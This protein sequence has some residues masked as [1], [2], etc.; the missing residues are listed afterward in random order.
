MA[1]F[2][3][4][5]L[6]GK[7]AKKGI[8]Y[9][10]VWKDFEDGSSAA[11]LSYVGDMF[12]CDRVLVLLRTPED[13]YRCTDEWCGE[14]VKSVRDQLQELTWLD[15]MPW[16]DVVED[17]R[18]TI[19]EDVESI[20]ETNEELY[21]KLQQFNPKAVIM[22]QLSHMG[23]DL[24]FW[25][26]VNPALENIQNVSAIFQGIFYLVG[27]LY[28]SQGTIEK[29]KDIGFTD[30]LTGAANRNALTRD[31]ELFRVGVPLAILF[32]DLNGMKEINDT[33]GHEAGDRLL[34][35]ACD[36]IREVFPPDS[37][38]RIGGDEFL[39]ILSDIEKA[40]FFEKE[41]KV[42][43]SFKAHDVQVAIGAVYADSYARN[44]D[45]L[46]SQAD[47]LMYKDKKSSYKT[48]EEGEETSSRPDEVMEVYPQE[49]GYRVI[50]CVPH[51]YEDRGGREKTGIFSQKLNSIADHQIH[52][53]DKLKYLDF[54]NVSSL[55]TNLEKRH[56]EDAAIIKY[57]ARTVDGYWCWVE[58][59]ITMMRRGNNKI[60]LISSLRDISDQ[61]ER[62]PI[63]ENL[64]SSSEDY[65]AQK[66]LYLNK[67]FTQQ[68]EDWLSQRR[69]G[70]PVCTIAVNLGHLRLYNDTFGRAAGDKLIQM[71]TGAIN[72][73]A[74]M[75]HGLAAY[76]GGDNF[77]VLGLMVDHGTADNLADYV[78]KNLR[79]Y[80]LDGGFAP[81]VG[82]YTTSD[83]KE[84]F[85]T[86][87]DRALIALSNVKD[88]YTEHVHVYSDSDF[89]TE[90]E[91]KRL[92][93]Q[94]IQMAL[95]Q[96]EF[97][98]Y[99]QP[100]VEIDTGRIVGAESLIRWQRGIN[101][102]RAESFIDILEESGY[103]L[104]LDIRMWR[105]LFGWMKEMKEKGISVPPCSINIAH[106]DFH[107][108]KVAETLIKLL[109]EYGLDSKL[110]LVE[111]SEL[112]YADDPENISS[113]IDI[114][115]SAGIKV[116]MDDSGCGFDSFRM[117]YGTTLDGIKMNQSYL[118]MLPMASK[119]F[120][121]VK[122]ML[123]VGREGNIPV[124]SEGA[125]TREQVENLKGIGCRY[126]QGN[127][128]YRPMTLADFEKLLIKKGHG[129]S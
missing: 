126:I 64:T 94:E 32:A 76:L 21:E 108:V 93:V 96:D 118:S 84:T 99:M 28:H 114:M 71:A 61:R 8:Q 20:K 39:V 105:S 9:R 90:T 120:N 123:D 44:F 97:K 35:R 107:Y 104:S 89:R 69:E 117:L 1:L 127:C 111:L 36:A 116:F 42:R 63:S 65:V 30:K 60:V 67:K 129:G 33:E 19:I 82:I 11:L 52:P 16:L 58:E 124:I 47:D 128:Y 46:K 102:L 50:Y 25:L 57:R 31:I 83:R 119:A 87:H 91:S 70:E 5:F 49:N 66:Q 56:R 80:R 88:N 98:C 81:A 3:F 72:Q 95:I 26:V 22:G 86:M 59:Q 7:N 15:M 101:L 77:C 24:G 109:S 55:I 115:R 41:V 2:D 38:Y 48:F 74:Y 100:I 62:E 18:V 51:K 45:E 6:T 73:A 106:V 43:E 110:L 40:E 122:M 78:R 13:T 29:L 34:K 79:E 4:T 54:W 125:E 23:E 10:S 92:H 113:Q 14:G 121:P 53:S 68:A 75:L 112:T 103:I 17:G 37:L 27:N 85:A 12:K